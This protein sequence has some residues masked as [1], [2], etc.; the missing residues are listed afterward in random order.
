MG[1]FFRAGKC[2]R[3]TMKATWP[4]TKVIRRYQINFLCTSLAT[5]SSKSR[6]HLMATASLPIRL[7]LTFNSP[8]PKHDF[9]KKKINI[10]EFTKLF[11]PFLFWSK[12]YSDKRLTR[13]PPRLCARVDRLHQTKHFAEQKLHGTRGHL[14]CTR[15][16]KGVNL[17]L[18][19]EKNKASASELLQSTCIN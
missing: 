19:G 16:L 11:V 2:N 9:D 6:L 10:P 14:W 18:S 7:L 5:D 15:W 13:R 12:F 4:V 8:V 1:S 3:Y 17:A